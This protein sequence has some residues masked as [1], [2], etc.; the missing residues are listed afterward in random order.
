MVKDYTAKVMKKEARLFEELDK[1]LRIFDAEYQICYYVNRGGVSLWV[2]P[3]GECWI[4]AFIVTHDEGEE[5]DFYWF[6]E[7][8]ESSWDIGEDMYENK[9][10]W[11]YCM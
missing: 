4:S 6:D 7:L 8:G 11:V 10:N 2:R 5:R 1:W 9:V 3:E